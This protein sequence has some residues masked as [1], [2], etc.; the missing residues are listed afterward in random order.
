MPKRSAT[1]PPLEVN[2]KAF[3]S[4]FL[5]TCSIRMR[6]V[7]ICLGKR[8]F[9]GNRK[10]NSFFRGNHRKQVVH[11][12]SDLGRSDRRM[13][14]F[15]LASFN[16]R[17]IQD[18]VDNHQEVIARLM[19]DIGMFNLFYLEVARLVFSAS[20]LASISTLLRGVRSSCDMLARNADFI[21]I[22]LLELMRFEREG[23]SGF[24]LQP[25]SGP[26]AAALSFPVRHKL[27]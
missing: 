11:I 16:F 10:F 7:I 19:N 14:Q 17:K 20:I 24:L 9:Y 15:N 22:A 5:I 27:F 3:E 18:V 1:L 25:G 21:L 6:S 13:A 4:R 8:I 26:G 23:L 2:L 12:V